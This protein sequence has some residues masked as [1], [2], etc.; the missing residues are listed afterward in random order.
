MQLCPI[1][2]NSGALNLFGEWS[3]VDV[4][5]ALMLNGPILN[6]DTVPGRLID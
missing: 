5:L 6:G 3:I 2:Q 1:R 4:D